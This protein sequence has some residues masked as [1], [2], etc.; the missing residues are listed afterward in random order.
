MKDIPETALQEEAN[1]QEPAMFER[2]PWYV[3]FC[4]FVMVLLLTAV[5]YS[6]CAG[7]IMLALGLFVPIST[8]LAWAGSHMVAAI[9]I[10]VV[11][12]I[13]FTI[14]LM[15]QAGMAVCRDRTRREV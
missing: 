4:R 1:P 8:V 14:W 9:T 5:G 13:L 11:S 3:V 7:L 2:A 10:L 12:Y 6:F 15:A